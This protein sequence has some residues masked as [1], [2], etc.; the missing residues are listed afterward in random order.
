MIFAVSFTQSFSQCIRFYNNFCFSKSRFC[1]AS[2]LNRHVSF[3][4]K[5]KTKWTI[6]YSIQQIERSV[7]Q[8]RL[9]QVWFRLLSSCYFLTIITISFDSLKKCYWKCFTFITIGFVS[10]KSLVKNVQKFIVQLSFYV[11]FHNYTF[12]VV[13]VFLFFAKF[14]SLILQK[15]A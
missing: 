10:S 13:T 4:S 6:L 14:S 15:I 8:T 2:V 12:N 3:D 11:Y 5:I 1:V 7:L 9:C